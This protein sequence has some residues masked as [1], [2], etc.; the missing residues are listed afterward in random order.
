MFSRYLFS[1]VVQTCT[2]FDLAKYWNLSHGRFLL[3]WA[4]IFMH[5]N[6]RPH[7]DGVS[8]DCIGEEGI[9]AIDWPPCIV[10]LT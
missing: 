1:G 6:A 7:T 5:D 9:D 10:H 4:L 3:Q 8:M 2:F